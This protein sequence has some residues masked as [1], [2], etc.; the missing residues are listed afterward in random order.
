MHHEI[1]TVYYND[2]DSEADGLYS[3]NGMRSK[4][5]DDDDDDD[6]Q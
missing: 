2:Y 3:E 6:Q 4:Y 5:D 1:V